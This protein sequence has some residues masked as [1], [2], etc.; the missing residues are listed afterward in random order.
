MGTLLLD[1][2]CAPAVHPFSGFG[3]TRDG[4][5]HARQIVLLEF[6]RTRN[7]GDAVSLFGTWGS[8]QVV[9]STLP[10]ASVTAGSLV[11]GGLAKSEVT[12]DPSSTG[13][14]LTGWLFVR[15]V[16]RLSA[17]VIAP[18]VAMFPA[19]TVNPIATVPS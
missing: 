7:I 4:S 8:W 1:V 12:S 17:A 18:V 6:E 3:C 10:A 14:M 15:L 9:H 5:W 16:V 19:A 13:F 11:V 2:A